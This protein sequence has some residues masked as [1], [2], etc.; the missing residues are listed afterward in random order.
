VTFKIQI[1]KFGDDDT[2]EIKVDGRVVGWLE[3]VHGER[4]ASATSRARVSFV[5]HYS[6]VLTDDFADNHLQKHDVDSRADAK[7]EVER[8]FDRAW[9]KL[10]SSAPSAHAPKDQAP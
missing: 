5:S 9:Q 8:T 7:L 10:T 6:I 4:F 3:R 1:G 2:A